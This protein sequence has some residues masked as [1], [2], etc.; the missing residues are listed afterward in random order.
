MANYS[1]NERAKCAAWYECMKSIVLVQRKYNSIFGKNSKAPNSASIRKWHKSL[2]E[3]GSVCDLI[4]KRERTATCTETQGKVTD[5][6]SRRPETS[7]RRASKELKISHESIRRCLKLDKWHPYKPQLLHALK[8]HDYSARLSFAID[9]LF[10]IS[11]SNK[12]LQRIIFSDEANFHLDGKVNRHNCRYWSKENPDYVL[13]IPLHSPKVVVWAAI[14]QQKIYG[15]FF[16]DDNV[17]SKNYLAMLANNFYPSLTRTEQRLFIFMQDGAPPHW[18]K[19]VR[20]WLDEKFK[21]RWMGRGS[22]NLPWPARSPDITPCDFFMWG[23]L[24]SKVYVQDI[25]NIADL[26]EKITEAFLEIT[27]DMLSD[28][29]SNYWYRLE[30]VV[31]FKGGHIEQE[32]S[33]EI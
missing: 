10:R 28:V 21:Q 11:Q 30:K 33:S 13:E 15:P 6:F 3:I 19:P 5:L 2:M 12:Y 16:F 31:E 32:S 25:L 18:S 9:E 8:D 22:S 23:F 24:K 17:N 29:F 27:K 7:L 14:S 20:S 26:K 4:R 1:I